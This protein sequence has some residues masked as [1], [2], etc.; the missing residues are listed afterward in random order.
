MRRCVQCVLPEQYPNIEFDASGVCNFCRDYESPRYLGEDALAE[1]FE[2]ARAKSGP[3][4]CLVPWSGGRDST[5]VLVQLVRRHG[6]K[7]AAYNF[8][9]GFTSEVAR[10]N[11]E[12]IAERL[13]IDMIYDRMPDHLFEN[14]L[15]ELVR[16]SAAKSPAHVPFA[17]CSICG[18]GIWGGAY[19]TAADR[20]IPLVVFGESSME[21]GYAKRIVAAGLESTKA[22]KV[23]FM[24]TKPVNF[25]KRRLYSHQCEQL[26]PRESERY[27]DLQRINYFDYLAW[28]E[29]RM[30]ETLRREVDWQQERG[31]DAWRFDCMIHAVVDALNRSL[32]G[33]TEKEE[34]LSRMINEG[35]ID[36][37]AALARLEKDQ[38]PDRRDEIIAEV[39]RRLN[40]D[41]RT[42]EK[43]N[44]A[45]RAADFEKASLE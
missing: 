38:A 11:L 25:M 40:L 7:V 6:L 29:N 16:L 37:E 42:I 3:Y 23:K 21:R 36:R 26:F 14:Y 33:Y 41:R 18:N 17:L 9:N 1:V 27:R 22:E 8:D 39:Y 13:G 28:D 2:Q 34:L 31:M 5:Y 10:R 45:M 35:M 20:G 30:L 12:S 32:Y 4:E 44:T 43:L 19:R 15:R 24:V